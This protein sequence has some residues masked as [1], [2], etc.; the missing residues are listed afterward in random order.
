[1][2]R[3][4]YEL[5]LNDIDGLGH[6]AATWY[7]G[8]LEE[9]RAAWLIK[10]LGTDYPCCVLR[11]QRIEYLREIRRADGTV[12]VNLAVKHLG[13]SSIEVAEEISAGGTVRARSHAVLVMWDRQ[14]RAARPM[15]DDERAALATFIAPAS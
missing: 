13:T 2:W 9:T 1:M 8:L 6:L 14:T 12:T 7:L 15:T 10:S 11:A 5:R 4:D 3:S